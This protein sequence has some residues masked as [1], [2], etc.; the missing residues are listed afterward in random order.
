MDLQYVGCHD[1]E[2]RLLPLGPWWNIFG[3]FGP[4]TIRLV[5]A[6]GN[7]ALMIYE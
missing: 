6:L 3:K 5:R 1:Y 4:G 2:R 7:Y